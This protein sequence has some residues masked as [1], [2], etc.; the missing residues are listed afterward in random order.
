MY[1]VFS[2]EIYIHYF[3]S[4]KKFGNITLCDARVKMIGLDRGTHCSYQCSSIC[5]RLLYLALFG[6]CAACDEVQD[7]PHGGSSIIMSP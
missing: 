4:K 1:K 5:S 2:L 3:L 6:R 7:G